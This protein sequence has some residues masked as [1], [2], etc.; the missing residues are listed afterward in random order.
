MKRYL[1]ALFCLSL[2]AADRWTVDDILLQEQVGSL[3]LSRD[4]R[5]A[6]FVKSR[7]DKEKGESVSHLWLKRFG[8]AEA[9]QLTRGQ[10][11]ASSPKFSPS[12]RLIAF[13]TSRRPAGAPAQPAGGPGEP[14]GQQVWLMYAYGGEPWPLTRFERGVR[15]FDWISDDAIA[16]A[17]PEDPS[18][19]DQKIKEAKDTSRVV[20][21][22]EHE[23]PVRLFRVEVKGGK[24]T[25]ITSNRDRITSVD[26]SPDGQWA[27]TVHNRSLAE[28][29][30]QKI[31]PATFLTRLSSGESVELF[32]GQKLYPRSFH[33]KA[34]SKSF[35]FTAPYTTHP[36]L[37]NASVTRLYHFPMALAEPLAAAATAKPVE[38]AL[39][40]DNGLAA[41]PAVAPDGF[42]ALLANGARNRVA[43]YY[44]T[45]NAWRREWIDEPDVHQVSV[46]TDGGRI[47]Y[48]RSNASTPPVFMAAR[49]AGSRFEEPAPFIETNENF[50]KKTIAKTEVIRWKGALDDEIEGILYYPHDYQPGRK[51][52]LV[53]MIHGGPHGHDPDAFRESWAYP[54]QLYAQRGAFILKPNY[55][56]SSNYG[57]KFGESISGGKYN[58]LE[59]IDV[60]KGVDHLIAKGLVDPEKLG[61]LGWSNG[62]I[63]SIELSV[64]TTRYKAV[65]AGAGDV[66][67]TSDWGN[68]V[69]GDA[70]EQYY[71]GKTP[72][73]DPDF[74]VKK[75]PLFK[76]EKVTSPTIIFF[77]TEDR[78]VPTEQ[79]WQHYR[80]LQHYGKTP[81]RFILFPGEPHSLRKYVHQKRKVEEELAWFDRYLFGAAPAENP[82]LKPNSPL[83]ALQRLKSLP[84]V[85]ETVDR[86]SI[87]IGRFEVTRAQFRAFDPGYS[88]PA[89]TELYPATNVPF[90]K[91]QQYCEWLSKKT[92]QKYRLGSED[93]LESLLDRNR[94]E[95]TLD[96]WA[97][98]A[99]N[100]DDAAR[101]RELVDQAG[102]GALLRPVGSFAGSG[103]DPLFDLGGNAAEWVVGK[104]GK[105]KVLGGSA[106][107]PA[108][109]KAPVTSRPD[110]IGFRVVRDK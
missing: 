13:L 50:R 18:L 56:G 2:S 53:V 4:G 105:G 40:W 24:V 37:Y 100:Y 63:I 36:Y 70:F 33:W 20:D 22:E 88:V 67:W 107:Q 39:D 80:A 30:N 26:V 47:V 42:V 48:V 3:E 99:V 109:A 65:G 106:D 110:Y 85:P 98:Y 60:E 14:A 16:V 29:Y 7:I 38:V 68:A 11:G 75:S 94:N 49:L 34:D 78:Q 104:D 101:L 52:P 66:N 57:L 97:G 41:S 81:V 25:R 82:S 28:I 5:A 108:D 72:M 71:L 27:L 103:E 61:V 92:G 12:G 32:A 84:E 89:G 19:Y 69:F 83:A 1:F 55:H 64:R 76:M 31:K 73:D 87:A 91:A 21:D 10:D 95:N 86:G 74:Y 43:R 9:I 77:G 8:E 17:A 62:S 59:W 96:F 54:H 45:G 58:E 93:E 46:S 15:S 6:V 90:E 44:E 51:Y 102:P 23:P 79:G 35:Y